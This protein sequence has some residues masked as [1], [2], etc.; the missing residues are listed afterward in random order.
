MKTLT[1]LFFIFFLTAEC[2]SDINKKEEKMI[3]NEDKE[4]EIGIMRINYTL[5]GQSDSILKFFKT[6]QDKS[7]IYHFT[8]RELDEALRYREDTMEIKPLEFMGTPGR[9]IFRCI[10]STKQAYKI[11][12][13]ENS[14]N[15]CWLSK[16]SNI[17]FID[18]LSYLEGCD[19]IQTGNLLRT[20]PD[21]SASIV[22]DKDSCWKY[23]ILT[24]KGD[25]IE[26][27]T[28]GYCN[29]YEEKLN[30][31]IIKGWTKWR[32][33]NKLMVGKMYAE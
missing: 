8:I 31:Q 2:S 30:R 20:T 14:D 16:M 12:V 7:P 9:I 10:D 3:G 33:G 17:E 23:N 6:P 1:Q 15:F 4:L 18:W 11:I 24:M 27:Q 28:S 26:V 25:W 21:D 29:I 22:F 5:N 19:Y 13:N 32:K